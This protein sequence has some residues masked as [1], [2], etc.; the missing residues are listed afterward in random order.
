MS[1]AYWPRP[2]TCED[3][4][5]RRWGVPAGQAGLGIAAGERLEVAAARQAF[6]T[7]ALFAVI[8]TILALALLS[9]KAVHWLDRRMTG[10]KAE[11]AVE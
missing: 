11:I 5:S 3:G 1:G 10:W 6:A 4:G 9:M 8:L 2:W 7:D